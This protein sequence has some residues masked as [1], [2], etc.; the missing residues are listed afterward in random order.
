MRAGYFDP[1]TEQRVE[2]DVSAA[3]LHELVDV[4]SRLRTQRGTPTIEMTKSDGST[5]SFSFDDECAFLVWTD[6]LGESSHSL[7]GR[8]ERDLVFDYFGSWSE[9]PAEYLVRYADGL[10]AVVEFLRVGS[11]VTDSII[12]SPD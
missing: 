10:A 8:F 12:F 11:P 1:V 4:V 3:D 9:A 7:G 6:A 5:L 2:T